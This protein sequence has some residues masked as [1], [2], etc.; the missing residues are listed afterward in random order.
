MTINLFLEIDSGRDHRGFLE[1]LAI[2]MNDCN[3]W[4]RLTITCPAPG[5]LHFT[6]LTNDFL[7]SPPFPRHTLEEIDVDMGSLEPFITTLDSG[8]GTVWD[9]LHI[10]R[11]SHS[12]RK[13]SIRGYSLVIGTRNQPLG[14][15]RIPFDTLREL[16]LDGVHWTALR[17]LSL[18]SLPLL[19][20]VAI[21]ILDSSPDHAGDLQR[22]GNER[23]D[24]PSL[25]SAILYGNFTAAMISFVLQ[26]S[27]SLQQLAL[28]LPPPNLRASPGTLK[29]GI[30]PAL[31]TL[32]IRTTLPSSSLEQVLAHWPTLHHL[33]L[34]DER[35]NVEVDIDEG[36]Q[37][38]RL[39]ADD[40]EFSKIL[41][42][43][44]RVCR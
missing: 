4:K 37:V 43:L 29:P 25:Q 19:E 31:T 34:C 11:H 44:R 15:I 24:L 18:P 40:M 20:T 14:T 7:P 32:S 38:H 8:D 1:T 5:P 3:T 41:D 17:L 27:P 28:D 9:I 35:R 26:G 23:I 13:L 2:A 21:R 10:A 33:V 16:R 22:L 30:P 6:L 12:L 39:G 42:Y 36:I